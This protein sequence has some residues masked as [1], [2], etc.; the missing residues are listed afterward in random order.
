MQCES[1]SHVPKYIH[2]VFLVLCLWSLWACAQDHC[3]CW[4]V[5]S[6]QAPGISGIL[7]LQKQFISSYRMLWCR[8]PVGCIILGSCREIK[9]HPLCLEWGFFLRFELSWWGRRAGIGLMHS[10][11]LPECVSI[12]LTD[13]AML[14]KFNEQMNESCIIL[15]CSPCAKEKYINL[16]TA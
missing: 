4:G 12:Y 6:Q 15:G 10:S 2:D 14:V 13:E 1:L 9:L 5:L 8:A 7:E 3:P 16:Q 11:I